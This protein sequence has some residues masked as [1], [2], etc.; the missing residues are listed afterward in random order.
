MK[1]TLMCEWKCNLTYGW[2]SEANVCDSESFKYQNWYHDVHGMLTPVQRHL[3]KLMISSEDDVFAK[4]CKTLR[5]CSRWSLCLELDCEGCGMFCTVKWRC[6][7]NGLC[8]EHLQRWIWRPSSS[9]LMKMFAKSFVNQSQ[10]AQEQEVM[11]RTSF[12]FVMFKEL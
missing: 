6:R 2:C 9:S 11:Q 10:K 4:F 7:S 5:L 1:R 8:L 3:Q 12:L